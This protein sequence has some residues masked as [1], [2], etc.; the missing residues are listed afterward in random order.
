M[1]RLL[2][3]LILLILLAVTE[4]KG[5]KWVPKQKREELLYFP[6][7]KFVEAITGGFDV[8]MSDFLWMETGNYFGKHR[9]TDKNYPYLYHMFDIITDLDPKFLPVYTLGT[10]MVATDA[11]E[12]DMAME[13]LNKG[14]RDNPKLWQ[15]PF[16]K[17][18]IYYVHKKDPLKASRWFLLA[19]YKEDAP[20]IVGKFATWTLY[21]SKGVEVTLSLYM[22]LYNVS[23]SEIFKEKAI[24]GIGKVISDQYKK[25][26]MDKGYYVESIFELYRTGYL[27][28]IPEIPGGVFDIKDGK[29]IFQQFQ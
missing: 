18:F 10:I 4:R 15:I 24:K 28:F 6:S 16:T 8:L 19:S 7:N 5:F 1:K 9:R 14:M 3:A 2:L 27:P 12:T 25:F 13:L 20:E 29:I 11:K 17:G 23:S 22:R 26:H 21:K